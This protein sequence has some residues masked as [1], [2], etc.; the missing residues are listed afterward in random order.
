MLISA[1]GSCVRS[2]VE[3]AFQPGFVETFILPRE[4]LQ[5]SHHKIV[6]LSGGAKQRGRTYLEDSSEDEHHSERETRKDGKDL[7]LVE[8]YHR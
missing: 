6:S 2:A 3:L 7:S 4:G 1:Y 5:R 8:F